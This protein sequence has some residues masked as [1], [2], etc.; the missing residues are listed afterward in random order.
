VVFSFLVIPAVIASLFA[1]RI[2]TRLLIGWG[3]GLM[4]CAVGLV[5]SYRLDLPSGPAVVASLG[6]ALLVAGLVYSILA[7]PS[8]LGAMLKAAAAVAVVVVSLIGL[9]IFFSSSTFLQLAHEHDWEAEQEEIAAGF[10]EDDSFWQKL[11]TDCG[12]VAECIAERL[13]SSPDAWKQLS[14]RL[15]QADTSEREA[16]LEALAYVEA[17]EGRDL[18]SELAAVETEPMVRLRA[19]QLLQE[20]DDPRGLPVAIEL[21]APDAP[22]LVRDEAYQL[23]VKQAGHDFGYDAFGDQQANAQ[24]LERI[25]AWSER[26]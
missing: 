16:W 15:Q 10:V 7:A 13:Q 23:L 3:V 2:S 12:G 25:R 19:A 21:L 26:F 22:P 20:A 8:R 14:A 11:G 9:S 4:A 1:R 18:I 5:A 17:P 6:G 24:A